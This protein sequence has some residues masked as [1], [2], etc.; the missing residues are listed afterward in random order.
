MHRALEIYQPTKY[1]IQAIICD[2]DIAHIDAMMSMTCTDV[3]DTHK[4]KCKVVKCKKIVLNGYFLQ[5]KMWD[6]NS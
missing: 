6:I 2:C 4:E 1:C 5:I 3:R